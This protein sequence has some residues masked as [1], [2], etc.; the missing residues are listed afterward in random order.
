MY[1][2]GGGR[3]VLILAPDLFLPNPKAVARRPGQ[4]TVE[5]EL[6][7]QSQGVLPDCQDEVTIVRARHEL[8]KNQKIVEIK[9][10]QLMSRKEVMKS[11]SHLLL[12]TKNDGGKDVYLCSASVPGTHYIQHSMQFVM[13]ADSESKFYIYCHFPL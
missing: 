12:T 11:I 5:D 9:S 8:D 1:A 6:K 7:L 10:G 13:H 2:V 3:D 4:L